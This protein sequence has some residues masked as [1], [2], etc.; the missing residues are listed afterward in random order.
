[1]LWWLCHWPAFG[2]WQDYDI[3]TEHPILN[4]DLATFTFVQ[5]E[6]DT[7]KP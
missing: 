2:Y 4:A 3:T 5:D 1:M 7:E 6:V